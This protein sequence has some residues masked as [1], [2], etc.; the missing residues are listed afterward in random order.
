MP[1]S[2]ENKRL[3]APNTARKAGVQGSNGS[4]TGTSG[5]TKIIQFF[6]FFF[7][8]LDRNPKE[9]RFLGP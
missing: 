8:F 3:T 6:L 5:Y 4:F 7:V 9:I 1:Y 2:L